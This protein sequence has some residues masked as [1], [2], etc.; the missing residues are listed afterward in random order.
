VRVSIRTVLYSS[1][2]QYPKKS[3]FQTNGASGNTTHSR[4]VVSREGKSNPSK[5]NPLV[6]AHFN[7]NKQCRLPLICGR[8]P[9]LISGQP[10]RLEHIF[11]KSQHRFHQPINDF[12][13]VSTI[14]QTLFHETLAISP[15]HF[16][17]DIF[18]DGRH[19]SSFEL[20][21]GAD[22][23]QVSL[24]ELPLL[25]FHRHFDILVHVGARKKV[26][27]DLLATLGAMENQGK[28]VHTG[29]SQSGNAMVQ[30]PLIKSN[31]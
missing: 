2:V 3:G 9:P 16:V 28:P 7:E 1:T 20:L 13:V 11:V 12:L 27:L 14:L 6:V 29:F 8:S 10:A 19:Q 23:L 15:H 31:A 17:D 26:E 4:F 5:S 21:F 24:L 30:S 25:L 18:V 22:M